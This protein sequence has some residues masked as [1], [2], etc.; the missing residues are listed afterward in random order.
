[1]RQ[2]ALRFLAADTDG[3]SVINTNNIDGAL[4]RIVDDLSSYYLMGY[5]TTNTKL[6][7][8]FR[9][10]TVRVKRP[11]ATVRAREGERGYTPAGLA[12]GV[13]PP[14]ALGATGGASSAAP[15]TVAPPPTVSFSARA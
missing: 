9:S 14:A 2:E 8:R 13:V 15:A 12:R 10:I 11:G 3:T 5:Y 6:D 7:G 4:R 1:N